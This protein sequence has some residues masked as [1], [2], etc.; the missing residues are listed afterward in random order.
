MAVAKDEISAEKCRSL[1]VIKKEFIHL[2]EDGLN[3]LVGG[4]AP[5][6]KKIISEADLINIEEHGID[7]IVLVGNKKAIDDAKKMIRLL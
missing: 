7:K 5:H 3:K 2:S 4:K 1:L 6:I